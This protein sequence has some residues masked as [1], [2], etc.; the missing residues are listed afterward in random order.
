M[1]YKW[2]MRS[3]QNMSGIHPDLRSVCD[4][5]LEI[6]EVD[7]IV[8]EG[9][10]NID[11]QRKLVAQGKSQTMNSRHLTGHAVDIAPYVNGGIS[12][13]WDY[14]YPIADAMKQAAEEL[15][16]DIEWG[17][18][19]HVSPFH[20]WEGLA[21]GAKNDYVETRLSQ[22]RKPFPDGPHFQ[23]SRETYP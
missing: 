1:P 21:E 22:G 18:A 11:R 5:A 10:R 15:D 20:S 7:M 13:D 16:V 23:L 12:W 9:V 17:G 2:S 3:K 14:Y 6:T 19:W 4:R 8:I